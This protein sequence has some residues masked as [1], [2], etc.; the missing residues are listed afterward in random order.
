MSASPALKQ[1]C[2]WLRDGDEHPRRI[3]CVTEPDGV[4]EGLPPIHEQT[5]CRIA[6]QFMAI[7]RTLPARLPAE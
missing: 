7:D 2:R 6:K 5:G 3:I 1:A 4:I